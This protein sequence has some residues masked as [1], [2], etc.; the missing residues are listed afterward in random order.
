MP[1]DTLSSLAAASPQAVSLPFFYSEHNLAPFDIPVATAITFVGLI[2]LLILTFLFVMV[3]LAA[4]EAS[5]L[6]KKL[7]T[8]S[9]IRVRLTSVGIAYFIISLF[10]S[11]LSKA[12]QVD[13]SRK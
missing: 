4:R 6:E 10:Y 12:F 8:A 13:F 7:T 9:L 2:Y 5:G 3:G 1:A 11:L